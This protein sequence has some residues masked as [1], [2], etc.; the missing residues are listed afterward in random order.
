VLL[1]IN[2]RL[3]DNL[4]RMINYILHEDFPA[5]HTQ[6]LAIIAACFNNSTETEQMVFDLAEKLLIKEAEEDLKR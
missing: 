5:K 1:D 4:T 6:A 3:L 2:K